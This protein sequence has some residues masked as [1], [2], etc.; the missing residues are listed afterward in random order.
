GARLEAVTQQVQRQ[1]QKCIWLQVQFDDDK[2]KPTS[3]IK[4]KEVTFVAGLSIKH[5]EGSRAFALDATIRDLPSGVV[6]VA[7]FDRIGMRVGNVLDEFDLQVGRG[8]I[9]SSTVPS[10]GLALV[11]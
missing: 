9:Q 7:I 6:H 3:N 5:G 1:S 10:F 4:T 11:E 2:E 8:T